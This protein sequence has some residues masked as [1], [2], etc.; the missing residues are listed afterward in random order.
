MIE[1]SEA[2]EV[3]FRVKQESNRVAK[4]GKPADPPQSAKGEPDSEGNIHDPL[5]YLRA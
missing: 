4:E 5:R 3:T 2:V 1:L